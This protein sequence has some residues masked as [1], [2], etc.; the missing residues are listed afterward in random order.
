MRAVVI[1]FSILL[2]SAC[3]APLQ[4]LADSYNQADPCQ[5]RSELGRPAGY[6]RP[7]WCG[8]AGSR[9]TVYDARGRVW[10]YV[11]N[12]PSNSLVR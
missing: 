5:A 7:N 11:R 1:L 8:A 6:Q 12:T 2:L 9:T 10:G 3:S 4:L